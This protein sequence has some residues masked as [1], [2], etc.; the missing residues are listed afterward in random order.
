MSI[1]KK[2]A[3]TSALI[4]IFSGAQVYAQSTVMVKSFLAESVVPL[5]NVNGVSAP[6]VSSDVVAALQ[7]NALELREQ[8]NYTASSHTALVKGFLVQPGSPIPTPDNSG[9]VTPA[10]NYTV[11]V[12]RVLMTKSSGIVLTGAVTSNP[13]GSPFGDLT[14]DEVVIA[15]LYKIPVDPVPVA[16]TAYTA[17]SVDIIGLASLFSKDGAG[18]ISLSSGTTTPQVPIA[19]AGKRMVTTRNVF[20]LS[21]AGSS[22]PMGGTLTYSWKF[23]AVYGQA[24]D[25]LNANTASPTVRLP[26]YSDAVGDYTFQ[27]TVTNSAGMSATDTVIVTYDPASTSQNQ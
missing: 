3:L 10:W 22:D 24:A 8:I 1:S 27:L 26:D 14:G 12:D 18:T 2:G 7:N 21:A 17:V 4:L 11:S 19:S 5:A 9:G 23:I 13:G 16:N 15:A 6:N 25:L 20:Q